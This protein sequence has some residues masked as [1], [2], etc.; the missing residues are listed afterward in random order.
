MMRGYA[1]LKAQGRMGVVAVI[2]EEL[3]VTPIADAGMLASPLLR[4]DGNVIERT[5]RQLLII[6]HLQTPLPEALYRSAGRGLPVVFPMPRVWREVVARKGFEVAG[7]RCALLWAGT[8]CAHWANGVRVLFRQVG[9]CLRAHHQLPLPPTRYAYFDGLV[10]ANLPQGGPDPGRD[11]VIGWYCRW[12]D[13]AHDLSAIIHSAAAAPRQFA[14][15]RVQS[16]ASPLPL[17]ARAQTS[18]FLAHGLREAAASLVELTRGRWQRAFGLA[19]TVRA[20]QASLAQPESLARDYLFHNS[21]WVFRPLWTHVA[22]SHGSR[23]LFFF[24][25]ANCEKFAV[26]G[27]TSSIPFGWKAGNWP[28][29][30]AWDA[31]QQRFLKRCVGAHTNMPIVGPM[32]FMSARTRSVDLVANKGIAVF[33]VQPQRDSLYRRLGLDVEYYIPP[34][35]KAFIRE[36]TQ[37]V[38]GTGCTLVLKRKRDIG[39]HLHPAYSREIERSVRAPNWME[40]PPETLALDVIR[41]CKAV[42]SMPYTSTALVARHHGKP[43]VYY[44][45]S[46]LIARDDPAAH[47]IPIL[48][49]PEELSEWILTVVS[50]QKEEILG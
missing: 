15:W 3:T 37:A 22:E 48:Q 20:L 47:G 12:S 19:E 6:R 26:P 21:N 25:S 32:D 17:L 24:Y 10:E 27:V 14:N 44:D 43:S 28:V 41:A 49:T 38:D 13:R 42:V 18:Q 33:D 4:L 9:A 1:R 23:I 31:T 11:G 36:L 8:V 46:R 7:R 2:R 45:A 40:V 34:I 16:A 29:M 5:L 30:L 35:A 39:R 50:P